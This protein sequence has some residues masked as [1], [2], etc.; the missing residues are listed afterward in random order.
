[1]RLHLTRLFYWPPTAVSNILSECTSVLDFKKK[2]K[3]RHATSV[4]KGA[5]N[6]EN[7]AGDKSSVEKAALASL[8][9]WNRGQFD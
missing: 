2:K 8:F 4:I 9:L 5:G 1:M 3:L 7:C 6:C